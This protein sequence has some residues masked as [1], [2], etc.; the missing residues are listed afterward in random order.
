M[1]ENK[2]QGVILEKKRVID[3]D[4]GSILHI[5]DSSEYVFENF[6]ESYFS[7]I[8]PGKIK[9][10]KKHREMTINLVVIVG[11][12]KFVIYDDREKSNTKGKFMDFTLS[13][14]NY[15]RLTLRPGLWFAFQC[16]SKQEAILLNIANIKHADNEIDRKQINEIEYF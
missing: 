10:W 14:N 1:D 2:I 16:M 7:T 11:E 12:I 15:E 6:G 3:L 9:G 13:R 5:L 8:K 4:D